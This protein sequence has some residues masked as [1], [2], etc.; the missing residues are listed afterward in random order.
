MVKIGFFQS[1]IVYESTAKKNPNCQNIE[2][3][4]YRKDNSLQQTYAQLL[5]ARLILKENKKKAFLL[6]YHIYRGGK[7]SVFPLLGKWK[8]FCIW[9][10]NIKCY[11]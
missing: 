7:I 2:R 4:K 11:G 1:K 6:C 9:K 10:A 3:K 8:L 5:C